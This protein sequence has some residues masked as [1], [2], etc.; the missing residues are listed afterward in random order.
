M[1]RWPRYQPTATK[2]GVK[3]K[4]AIS[5]D[6][7]QAQVIS[8]AKRQVKVYPELTRLFHVPNG[9]QRHA[10]VAA[11]LQGQGVKPGVPDL[12]LPV[13]RFGCHGLWIEMKTQAGRVSPHQKDWIAFLR[14][15]LATALRFAAALTK[16]VMCC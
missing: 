4:P 9:G 3:V 16:R 8:W 12:C 6:V 2:A 5:E 11:K 14:C 1:S 10:A 13:P 7:I 15:V